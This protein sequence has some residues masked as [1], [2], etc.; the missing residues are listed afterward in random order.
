[1]LRRLFLQLAVLATIFGGAGLE[2]LHN[3]RAKAQSAWERFISQRTFQRPRNA[4]IVVLAVTMALLKLLGRFVE[5]GCI[6]QVNGQRGYPTSQDKGINL[7]LINR[8][9]VPT[10][11]HWHGLI[12]PNAMDGVP[13][14]T[15]PPIPP[16][17]RQ[18]IHYPLVQNGTFWMHSHFGLP[19]QS[20]YEVSSGWSQE[21]RC[22]RDCD[23]DGEPTQEHRIDGL[24][25]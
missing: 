20:Y 19:T 11:V 21:H 5:R 16:G 17:G 25:I 1:M 7:E 3:T 15:Q 8:L 18:R 13:F 4:D 6:R 14:V 24:K 23:D 10:T 22:T 12:L 9:T 2:F